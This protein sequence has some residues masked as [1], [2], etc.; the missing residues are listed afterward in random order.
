MIFYLD[1]IAVQNFEKH[2]WREKTVI[3]CS[4]NLITPV[5]MLLSMTARYHAYYSYCGG[6]ST[7][8]LDSVPFSVDR[9]LPRGTVAKWAVRSRKKENLCAVFGSAI[10]QPIFPPDRA[11]NHFTISMRYLQG[12][13][14]RFFRSNHCFK[15]IS[16]HFS[17]IESIQLRD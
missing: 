5:A 2:G 15:K 14:P 16:N 11:G 13:H 6:S 8:R 7:I 10:K 9:A 3:L 12:C 4:R 17:S 1:V